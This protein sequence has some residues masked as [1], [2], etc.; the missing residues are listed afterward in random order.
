MFGGSTRILYTLHVGTFGRPEISLLQTGLALFS[1]YSYPS[2]WV[3]NKI[4][5][6]TSIMRLDSTFVR[7]SKLLAHFTLYTLSTRYVDIVMY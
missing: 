6:I 2:S 5:T 1:G 4:I 3:I 7:T